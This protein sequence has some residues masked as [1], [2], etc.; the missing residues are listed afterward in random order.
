MVDLKLNAVLT[1]G[2]EAALDWL[3]KLGKTAKDN[4]FSFD[5]MTKM[6]NDA[7]KSIE[8]V[9]VA[10]A[11]SMVALAF[12]SPTVAAEFAKMKQPMFEIGETLG[13]EM[14]PGLTDLNSLLQDTSSW[15]KENTWFTEGL[16]AAFSTVIDISGNLLKKF[17]EIA[18][19][20]LKPIIEWAMDVKLGDKLEWLIDFVGK[21]EN[22]WIL[23]LLGLA[24]GGPAGLAIGGTIGAFF[25]ILKLINPEFGN[26][27]YSNQGAGYNSP[28]SANNVPYGG[29]S[30]ESTP[31][32][33]SSG[34]LLNNPDFL[35][36]IL[37]NVNI[38]GQTIT[39]DSVEVEMQ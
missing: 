36:N 33:S 1:P 8:T 29:T 31:T 21:A 15:L 25:D 5:N 39:P 23:G 32:N 11:A 28:W 6:M 16:G 20:H 35:K 19:T 37:I 14:K 13:K 24:V 3:E 27:N 7:F 10:S 18:V 12:A 22:T 4:L 9:A 38:N 2:S 30:S 34:S 17:G 26:P